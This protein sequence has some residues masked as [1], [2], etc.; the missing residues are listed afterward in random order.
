MSSAGDPA[1]QYQEDSNKAAGPLMP[2]LFLVNPR[3]QIFLLDRGK[4]FLLDKGK[5]RE[6]Y[7]SLS[8]IPERASRRDP[9]TE[10]HP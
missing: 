4:T 2:F 9:K 5:T 6:G 7:S 8:K 10:D 3:E 1:S